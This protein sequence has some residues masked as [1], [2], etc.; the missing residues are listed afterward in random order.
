MF[1]D[2]LLHHY[3]RA[4]IEIKEYFHT[5]NPDG[6]IQFHSCGAVPE[7]MMSGLIGGRT[8]SGSPTVDVYD[9]LPPKVRADSNPAAQKRRFGDNL[10]FL[11]GIDVQETLPLGHHRRG[12]RRGPRPHLGDG[13]QRRL[14]AELVA[15]PGA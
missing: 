7:Y 6:R 14:P 1:N 9:S 12:P 13:L 3:H 10:S 11:G 15:P 8:S 4:C 2:Q 5:K